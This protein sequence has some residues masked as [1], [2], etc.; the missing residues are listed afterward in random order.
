MPAVAETWFGV[1]VIVIVHW[2]G[3]NQ[4]RP[5]QLNLDF[6]VGGKF[7]SGLDIPA[8]STKLGVPRSPFLGPQAWG[9]QLRLRDG[10]GG[11]AVPSQLLWMKLVVAF[12]KHVCSI[13]DEVCDFADVDIT[14]LEW[15]HHLKYVCS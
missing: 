4:Y 14:R 5:R 6:Q 7:G 3:E 9:R 8:K 1:L 15:C 12:W 11:E 10:A 13:H 2:G